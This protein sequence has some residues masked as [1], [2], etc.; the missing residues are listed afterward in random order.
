MNSLKHS[1]ECLIC[2][3][4]VITSSFVVTTCCHQLIHANCLQEMS[5]RRGVCRGIN[6]SLER[7]IMPC[8]GCSMEEFS[9]RKMTVEP[10]LAHK[11]LVRE[12]TEWIENQQNKDQVVDMLMDQ[13][14]EFSR[15]MDEVVDAS[16]LDTTTDMEMME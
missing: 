14:R 1:V 2:L 13:M 6:R 8:P 11:R 4:N 10:N 3:E 5:A 7:R 15:R 16:R 12:V 9:V